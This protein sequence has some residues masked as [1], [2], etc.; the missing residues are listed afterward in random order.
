VIAGIDEAGR[1]PVVGPLVV[2]M[3]EGDQEELRRL[4]VKDSKELSPKKRELLFEKILEVCK[5]RYV[6]VEPFVIDAYVVGGSLNSLEAD[7]MISLIHS[8]GAEKIFIDAPDVDA[9]RFGSL[10]A[11]RTGREVVAE[12]G[13]DKKYPIVSAASIVAK[14]IRDRIIRGISEVYGEVGSGYPHDATTIKFVEGWIRRMG[15]VPSFVRSSWITVRRIVQR[16]WQRTLEDY[17]F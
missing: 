11:Q 13:A 14:V 12:H 3:V 6:R 4:G 9:Q 16:S 5:V 8:S 7:V 1:G 2:A 15:R 10:I 17:L